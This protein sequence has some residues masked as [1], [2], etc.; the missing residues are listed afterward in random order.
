[1]KPRIGIIDSGV[2]EVMLPYVAHSKRFSELAGDDF[3]EPDAVGHGDQL[4]RVIVQ[5]CNEAQLYI[6]QVFHST[7]LAPI[8]RIVQAIDWLVANDIQLINMS[9]G[10][11]SFSAELELACRQAAERGVILFASSPSTGGV[12]YP[13]A[14]QSCLAVTGDVRCAGHQLSWLN[15]QHAEFGACSF[16]VP[17][18][19]HFGG[20]ASIACARITGM[21]ARL[22][23]LQNITPDGLA[24]TLRNHAAYV[25][26]ELRRR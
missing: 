11:R 4:A 23:A 25:G 2:L 21:A 1:V 12:V 26:P 9:F 17:G 6:A 10:V 3:A 24:D 20:G 13:A 19:P 18:N 16:Q 15:Q 7:R 8:S 22:L 14:L 5:Q